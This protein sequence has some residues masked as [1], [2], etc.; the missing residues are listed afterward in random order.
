MG[1]LFARRCQVIVDQLQVED[2]RV[3]F[4][5]RKDVGSNPNTAEIS[6]TNLSE[7]TRSNMQ[8][9][10][11][12]VV[13]SAG[14]GTGLAVIFAGDVRVVDHV[15]EGP[16]W[17]TKIQAGDAEKAHRKIVS[18]SFANGTLV[19]DAIM[20]M[21]SS[22]GVDAGNASQKVNALTAQ[23]VNGYSVHGRVSAELETLL[24]SQGLEYSIQDGRLQILAPD[25]TTLDQAVDLS[26]STGMV[27]SPEHGTSEKEGGAGVVK[28]RS[29]LQPRF[30]PGA[31]INVTSAG[32]NG[33]LRIQK[34][35]HRGD[36]HGGDW[37]SDLEAIPTGGT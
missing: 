13:L 19:K 1:Q 12:P 6:I 7:S 37:Y 20:S 16:S 22:L 34:L 26:A 21:V 8:T 10:G 36:T 33:L 17:V 18:S 23:F 2:L 5:V 28:V 35:E 9:K 27:G 25:E 15:R 4:R 11:V 3:A 24:R 31:K 14:Y 32:V 29:L 30:K